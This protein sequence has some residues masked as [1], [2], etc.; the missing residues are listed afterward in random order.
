[1][2]W[3]HHLELKK[4][5]AVPYRFQQ[6]GLGAF[7]R[8]PGWPTQER[9]RLARG[10]A[11]LCCAGLYRASGCV[12]PIGSVVEYIL[13]FAQPALPRPTP[14]CSGCSTAF[15]PGSTPF[16]PPLAGNFAASSS[17][18][19]RPLACGGLRLRGSC[20]EIENRRDRA[21]RPAP[22]QDNAGF[23][24]YARW[25]VQASFMLISRGVLGARR[26]RAHAN[27]ARVP[28]S[29]PCVDY[30]LGTCS[31]VL[32]SSLP[33]H[34][35]ACL[36]ACL[37]APVGGLLHLRLE[38]V[39]PPEVSAFPFRAADVTRIMDLQVSGPHPR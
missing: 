30:A 23:R 25:N 11:G 29:S 13:V 21:S 8:S 34:L 15:P 22:N 9:R 28:R 24:Q 7:Q 33:R 5:D 31:S 1:M 3:F 38:V 6:A 18:F 14:G 2:Y 32:S 26:A 35:P 27:P 37:P 17:L 16:P 20:G 4:K 19:A 36:P 10:G 12:N 39:A